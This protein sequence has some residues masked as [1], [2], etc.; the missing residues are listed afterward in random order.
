MSV[1]LFVLGAALAASGAA[2]VS[3]APESCLAT[4]PAA[5]AAACKGHDGWSDP[6]PPVHVFGNTWDVGTCGITALLVSSDKGYVLV[7]AGMADAAQSVLANIRRLGVEPRQVKWIVSSHEHFD[8]AGGLAELKRATGAKLALSAPSAAVLASGQP[9][10]DDPQFGSLK[11]M[12]PAQADRILA[13]G[14]TIALGSLTMTA[15]L[16]P[17][18]SP[19]STSWT[20][21][22]CEGTDCKTIAYADSLTMISADGYRFSDHPAY[23]ARARKALARVA[24]LPCDILVTP[25]PGASNLFARLHGEAPLNDPPLSDPGACKAYAAKAGQR[26]DARL[27]KEAAQSQEPRR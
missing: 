26:L 20:W 22:S 1:R 10:R 6:A 16:T 8:H 12:A 17:A 7:D 23:V 9:E 19:G 15:H 25:H 5:H 4:T 18:H 24:A 13:D 11:P 27:A 2:T 21:K 14:D 3:K